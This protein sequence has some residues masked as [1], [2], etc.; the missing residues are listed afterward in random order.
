MKVR[1]NMIVNKEE[2]FTLIEIMLSLVL[3]L[4]LIITFSGA[5]IWVSFLSFLGYFI[6]VSSSKGIVSIVNLTIL[7]VLVILIVLFVIMYLKKRF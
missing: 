2:G 6:G 4:L 3:I 7:I 1:Y 5:F